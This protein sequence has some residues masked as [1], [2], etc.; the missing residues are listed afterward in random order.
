MSSKIALILSLIYFIFFFLLGIDVMSI[1]LFYS[2]LDSK[3]IGISY[4][5]SSTGKSDNAY[6]TSLEEKYHVTIKNV[7]NEHPEFG[8]MVEYILEKD[9]Q[10][11]I[12]STSIL[13]IKIKRIAVVGYY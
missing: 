9:Y 5:I 6:I 2:R 1:Q 12:L 11:I 4:D 13:E 3:S 7:S 8:E 10:P